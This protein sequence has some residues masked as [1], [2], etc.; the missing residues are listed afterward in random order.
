MKPTGPGRRP[1]RMTARATAA[2]ATGERILAA[3]AEVFYSTGDLPLDDVAARAGVTVQTV[4]RRFG[5]RDGLFAAAL[6]R[7]SGRVRDQRDTA[8]V[9][10]VAAAVRVLLDHYDE[11][12][13]K[14]LTLLALENRS[15]AAAQVLGEGRL[16]HRSWCERVFAPAL[17]GLG[18]GSRA[19]RLAQ[20]VAVTDVYTWK[21]LRRDAGLSRDDVAL[22]LRELLDPLMGDH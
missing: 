11:Y 15:A 18:G 10:D 4:I 22:A 5:G 8:P 6:E 1:Y 9:G 3:A 17:A 13:D 16:L 2:A 20:L 7:E 19:R 12:G 21:L 14:V